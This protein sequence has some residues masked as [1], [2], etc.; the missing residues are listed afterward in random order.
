[1]FIRVNKM[2]H[3]NKRKIYSMKERKRVGERKQEREEGGG[4][5]G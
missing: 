4:E 3:R 5:K 1:M 2:F